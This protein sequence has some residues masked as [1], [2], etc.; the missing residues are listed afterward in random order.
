MRPN[1]SCLAALWLTVTPGIALGPA[2]LAQDAPA[3]G[4]AASEDGSTPPAATAPPP[5]A[6]DEIGEDTEDADAPADAPA[7]DAP[8]T[9]APSA[10]D[11][12]AAQAGTAGTD[13]DAGDAPAADPVSAAP[14]APPADADASDP[15]PD[16]ATASADPAAGD[17]LDEELLPEGE[18]EGTDGKAAPSAGGEAPADAAA[19]AP[20][21]IAA[22]EAAGIG[23]IGL[24]PCGQITGVENVNVLAQAAD[25]ALGYMAGRIDGGDTLTE[26]EP[27]VALDSTDVA[28]SMLIF[29]RANPGLPV[30]EAARSFG[31]RVFGTEPVTQSF[32]QAPESVPRP[33]P[34]PRAQTPQTGDGT[35]DPSPRDTQDAT[36][37]PG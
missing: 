2:A 22:A 33:R 31:G 4:D 1:F 14:T 9:D 16:A 13:A 5:A 19:D 21:I 35:Q 24:Q 20:D 28:T 27:L 12:G 32:A 17:I 25:W 36:E 30:I 29:C 10:P 37:Q 3:P 8:S 26:G 15:G 34:R 18:A 11:D 6:P 7:T 23:G